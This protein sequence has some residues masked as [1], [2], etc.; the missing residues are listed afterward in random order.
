MPI[1]VPYQWRLHRI[2]DE[3]YQVTIGGSHPQ[4]KSRSLVEG[5]RDQPSIH[6]RLQ[7]KGKE[8]RNN[9]TQ[10][11]LKQRQQTSSMRS[12]NLVLQKTLSG[13]YNNILYRYYFLEANIVY[14]TFHRKNTISLRNCNLKDYIFKSK[15]HYGLPKAETTFC[16]RNKYLL[17]AFMTIL[18]QY[19]RIF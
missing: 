10:K 5:K 14:L 17:L 19:C 12:N 9:T 4:N 3:I 2:L 16:F 8:H 6:Y 15:I 13:Q 7:V 1:F 18:T 11:Q